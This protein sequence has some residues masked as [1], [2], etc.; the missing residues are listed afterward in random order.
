MTLRTCFRVQVSSPDGTAHQQKIKTS[1][2]YRTSNIGRNLQIRNCN[3]VKG[4]Q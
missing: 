2:T 3:E 1:L 4:L